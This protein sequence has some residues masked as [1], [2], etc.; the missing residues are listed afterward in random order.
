MKVRSRT[1]KPRCGSGVACSTTSNKPG[2]PRSASQ[3]MAVDC[4]A[5]V[6]D[7]YLRRA[8]RPGWGRVDCV[9]AGQDA[10]ALIAT[11][12]RYASGLKSLAADDNLVLTHWPLIRAVVE[13]VAHAGWLLDPGITPEQRVARRW[14]SRLVS[15]YRSRWFSSTSGRSKSDI[16]TVKRERDKIKGELTNRFPGVDVDWSLDQDPNGPPWVVEEQTY[17]GLSQSVRRFNEYTGIHGIPDLYGLLS[18]VAHPTLHTV[19]ARSLVIETHEDHTTFS[20]SANMVE[21]FHL[22]RLA[23]MYI[24]RGGMV[25]G[26]YFGYDASQLEAWFD[27]VPGQLNIEP[28]DPHP[29]AAGP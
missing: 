9:H 29:P 16:R 27:T 14:M 18:L 22:L 15:H 5:L 2:R 8:G 26:S 10:I 17:P 25:V 1:P 23:G 19:I 13:H 12:V 7:L 11:A 4:P 28:S 6:E 21:T 3:P 24:Y 20:F